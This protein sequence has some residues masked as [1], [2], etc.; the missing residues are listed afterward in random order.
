MGRINRIA[1]TTVRT[2]GAV[3]VLPLIL[4]IL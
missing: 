2:F 4:F 1:T 3:V